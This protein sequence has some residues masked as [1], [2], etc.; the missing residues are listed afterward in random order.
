[1]EQQILEPAA[2]SSTEMQTEPSA[3]AAQDILRPLDDPPSEF[4]FWEDLKESMPPWINEVVGF[5]LII[6]GILS[7][8]FLVYRVRT[9][10]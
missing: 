6:F 8:I 4:D 3:Q 5:A 9:P 2:Q 10:W 1:M 7:F